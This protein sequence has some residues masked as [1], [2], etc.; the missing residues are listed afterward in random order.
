MADPWRF[1]VSVAAAVVRDDG[2][3]LAI[4]RRD[5]RHWEPPGG[6]VEPGETLHAALLREVEEETGIVVKV[7]R[8]S[9][10]YQN[11]PRNIVSIVFRCSVVSGSPRSSS[12]TLA[13]EW[14]AADEVK[15]RMDE[16]YSMRLLDA[17]SPLAAVRA[18]DG[19]RVRPD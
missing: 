2:R 13:V 10:V 12:E 11:V 17:L 16:A 1:S 7:D 15:R 4:Q 19:E 8:L 6:Q 5:N 3:L 9:G 14:L 18:H